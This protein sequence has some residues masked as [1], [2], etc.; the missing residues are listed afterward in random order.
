MKIVIAPDSF[1]ESLSAVSVAACIEKGFREIFPDAD[2][3]TLPLAD[4]GEGTVDVLLQGLFGEKRHSQVE[5]PLGQPVNAEWAMLEPSDQ[6][7]KK[8]ALIEIAAASGLNLLK[9]EQRDPL[10]ASSFGT[11]QLILEAIEQGAQTIILGLGGSATNDGGAGIVQA[12][13]GTLLDNAGQELNRGGV[14]LADLSSIDLTGLDS[15]YADIELIVA[16][17]VDNPLCGDNG[18]SHIFGPQKG[19]S[20]EQVVMLDK[21]LENF[22]QVVESQGCVRGDDPVHKRTGYGAAGGAPMG[23]GLLFNMQIKPGIEMVLDVLQAD[24]VLKGADLVIT[25][26]GQM[27]NQTLQGKTPYGIAKRASLQGI[28]TIGVAGSLGTEVEALYGEMSSLFGTVRSPQTLEKVLQE[29]EL[30]L[31][32]T[33]R[34]IAAT[35]RLGH[36]ISQK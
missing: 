31:T 21:A 28:P 1:K 26:E 17:D 18:A 16:C 27:D 12:L 14:A 15:R 8:T 10:I 30:N 32:R 36:K 29:A 20:P 13:G 9:P 7:P 35:L 25:G 22:A 11:G 5:G 23:L 2:Y 6:N 4:G 34:N 3:V 33:A 19:A 24:E